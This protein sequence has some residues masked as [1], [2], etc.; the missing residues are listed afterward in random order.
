[1]SKDYKVTYVK[2]V[3]R[4]IQTSISKRYTVDDMVTVSEL[5]KFCKAHGFVYDKMTVVVKI[6]NVHGETLLEAVRGTNG[7]D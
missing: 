4:D 3:Y 6:L 5:K 7:R 2:K 1:M